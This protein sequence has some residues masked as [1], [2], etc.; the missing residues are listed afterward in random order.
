MAFTFTEKI[1]TIFQ[2]IS[3]PRILK[4][5]LS[6]RHS[7][8]LIDSGWFKSY[9]SGS[10]VGKNNEPLPWMTYPFIE[11][12]A[13]RLNKDLNVFEFGSGNSTLFFS[14]RAGKV[15][16]VENN[17]YWYEK[18]AKLI[19]ANVSLLF[20]ENEME[21]FNAAG[22][23]NEFHII[24]VDGENR[25]HCLKNS[26]K[27]LRENGVIILDNSELK[28]YNPGIEYLINNNFKRIDF[29]GI[30]PGFFYKQ[31]TSIFYR[32]DNCLGI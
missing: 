9:L 15:V 32:R 7:G 17:K 12:I 14:K 6:L 4:F 10:P 16:S 21:Y 26:L 1:K 19:P 3:E 5:L 27:T 2:L 8:Y 22:N 30:T 23:K 29:W 11:F 25:V 28:E 31:S 18:I 13:Q 20:E 24:V